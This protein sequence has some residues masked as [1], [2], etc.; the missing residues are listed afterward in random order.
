MATAMISAFTRRKARRD[1]AMS[2]EITLRGEVLPI[3]GVKEKVLAARQ[4]KLRNIVLPRLN[5]RD[6]LQIG[7][8]ILH[9][10][11][12]HYVEDMDEV[13]KVALLPPGPAEALQDA[14]PPEAP[15]RPIPVTAEKRRRPIP[16]PS[17]A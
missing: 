7:Q 1:V 13:L 15:V 11:S 12:F 17:G 14:E 10:M 2:G 8:R 3:G 4:A 16:P 9:D 5:R 6:V